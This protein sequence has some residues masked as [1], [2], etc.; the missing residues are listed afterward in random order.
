MGV[1][2]VT[3]QLYHIDR[4]VL[5][6]VYTSFESHQETTAFF[7]MNIEKVLVADAVDSAC[8]DILKQHGILVDCK[9]KLSKSQLIEII[10]VRIFRCFYMKIQMCFIYVLCMTIVIQ[11]TIPTPYMQYSTLWLVKMFHFLYCSKR[12]K[13]QVIK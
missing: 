11:L 2:R 8:V 4:I 10:K 9:Y 6:A 1:S 13:N 12:K 3:I 5:F 7:A